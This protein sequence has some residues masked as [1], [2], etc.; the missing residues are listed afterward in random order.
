MFDCIS[1]P[2]MVLVAAHQIQYVSASFS[3]Y[4]FGSY[5]VWSMTTAIFVALI[6]EEFVRRR[7][8]TN[9]ENVGVYGTCYY[10]F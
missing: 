10:G 7:L 5:D 9:Q 3:I 8:R 4:T 6:S 2:S 1:E